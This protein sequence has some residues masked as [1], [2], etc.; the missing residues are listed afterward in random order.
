M[1]TGETWYTASTE[2]FTSFIKGFVIVVLDGYKFATRLPSK[3][4][5]GSFNVLICVIILSRISLNPDLEL[6]VCLVWHRPY[7]E[8][9]FY[10]RSTRFTHHPFPSLWSPGS[11][12]LISCFI[13]A[14]LFMVGLIA[15]L[16]AFNVSVELTAT[17][18]S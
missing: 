8:E 9:L 10:N 5:S 12:I 13:E 16:P 3:M 2:D 7:M 1:T 6:I 4:I 17:G 11:M 15:S 14:R 18:F